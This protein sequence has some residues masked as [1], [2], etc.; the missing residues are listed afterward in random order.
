MRRT[1][2]GI[3]LAAM[4]TGGTLSTEARSSELSLTGAQLLSACTKTDPEWIGFCNSYL[5][6]AIEA[7]DFIKSSAVVIFSL[8]G[9]VIA[10]VTGHR[11]RHQPRP[12]SIP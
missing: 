2:A 10:L 4:V 12:R 5:Q 7:A 9:L 6:A 8:L 1:L 11:R 3:V